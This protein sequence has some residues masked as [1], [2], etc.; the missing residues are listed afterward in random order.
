MENALLGLVL[1]GN[2][3]KNLVVRLRHIPLVGYG[4]RER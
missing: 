1:F 4:R 3:K 2:S